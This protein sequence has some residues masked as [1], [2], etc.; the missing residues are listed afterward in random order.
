LRPCTFL[1][2]RY[3]NLSIS[4]SSVPRLYAALQ[5]VDNQVSP[6]CSPSPPVA[7]DGCT[8]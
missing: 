5:L 8:Y 6:S 4:V 7:H 3:Y 1:P 2:F